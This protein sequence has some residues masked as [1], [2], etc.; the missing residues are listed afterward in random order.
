M[1]EFEILRELKEC[2]KLA[3]SEGHISE[4]QEEELTQY[5]TTKQYELEGYNE[6]DNWG[7]EANVEEGYYE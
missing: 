7:P 3:A 4:T 6:D 1:N 2:V 5:C